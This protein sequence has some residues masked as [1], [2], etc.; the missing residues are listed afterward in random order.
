MFSGDCD[1]VL[2]AALPSGTAEF[3]LEQPPKQNLCV[4]WLCTQVR[5]NPEVVNIFGW[6]L[7]IAAL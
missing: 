6:R 7:A 1:N 4:E 5:W 2:R 3:N